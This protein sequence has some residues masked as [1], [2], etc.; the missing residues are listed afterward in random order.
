MRR[1]R[2][3][4]HLTLLA[5]CAMALRTPRLMAQDAPRLLPFQGRLTDQNGVPV[6]NG[7]RMVQFKIYDQPI[8]GNVVWA[9]E[10]HQTTINGGLV[11]VLLGS[12]TPL[13]ST[14]AAGSQ[15][16]NQQLYLEITVDVNGDN[17]I[18]AADPPMLPRQVIL[19]TIFAKEAAFAKQAD[20]A[21]KLGGIAAAD[22]Q[23]VDAQ[24]LGGIFATNYVLGLVPVGSV[25]SFYGNTATLPPNWKVCDGSIVNDP[26]SPLSGQYLPDLREK[27]ARGVGTNTFLGSLGGQDT[28]SSHSHY[29]SDY[30][31]SVYIGTRGISG[32][33][34]WQ[35]PQS[36]Q[37]SW[38][39]HTYG[40]TFVDN[41]AGTDQDTHG[42]TGTAYVSGFTDSAGSGQ[43]NRPRFV[44]LFFIIRIR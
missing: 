34:G 14:N 44:S 38:F 41:V 2:I 21:N 11:N 17:A 39:P 30:S 13:P 9:G 7:V 16:F 32:W 3:T 29:F 31:A 22:F 10:V 27:F 18:T 20:N 6:T 5:V 43:D 33:N 37:G 35:F 25:I 36:I 23:A 42:H 26:L 12:K 8:A 19:P 4:I 15:I 24:K 40:L 28:T 1:L